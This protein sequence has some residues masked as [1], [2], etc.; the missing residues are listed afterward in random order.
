MLHWA[1]LTGPVVLALATAAAK[2]P[3]DLDAVPETY[4][5]A[6]EVYQAAAK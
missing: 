4:R 2:D 1:L 3:A 5:K 6:H